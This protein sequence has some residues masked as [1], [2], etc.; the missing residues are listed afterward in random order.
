MQKNLSNPTTFSLKTG[1]SRKAG[2]PWRCFQCAGNT[3]WQDMGEAGAGGKQGEAPGQPG[4]E[5]PPHH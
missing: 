5:Q 3:L 1:I 4:Q 2:A